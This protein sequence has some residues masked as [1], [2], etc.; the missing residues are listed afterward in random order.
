MAMFKDAA[1]AALDP[2]NIR[3]VFNGVIELDFVGGKPQYRIGGKVFPDLKSAVKFKNRAGISVVETFTPGKALVD[4]AT[5]SAGVPS[6]DQIHQMMIN[7]ARRANVKI[8]LHHLKNE[9][10][11]PSNLERILEGFTDEKT[12]KL[13][14]YLNVGK[15]ST[16]EQWEDMDNPGRFL[17][18][19]EIID[20]MSTVEKIFNDEVGSAAK[21]HKMDTRTAQYTKEFDRRLTVGVYDP[22]SFLKSSG[23]SG[24]DDITPKM[25][26]MSQDGMSLL[27]PEIIDEIRAAK[28]AQ[29][30]EYVAA[31]KNVPK[32][33]QKYMDITSEIKKIDAKVRELRGISVN[34]GL[35]N[36]RADIF[37]VAASS[38]YS[39]ALKG[40]IEHL[41]GQLKGN[42]MVVPNRKN[43]AGES[44][45]EAAQVARGFSRDVKLAVLTTAESI[46]QNKGERSRDASRVSTIMLDAREMIKSNWLDTQTYAAH[47]QLFDNARMHRFTVNTFQKQADELVTTGRLPEGMISAFREA[48][49]KN[50]GVVGKTS[51]STMQAKAIL[52]FMDN[53]GNLNQNPKMMEMA[54]NSLSAFFMD[55]KDS[56]RARF[57]V[58]NQVRHEIADFANMRSALVGTKSLPALTDLE[59]GWITLDKRLGFALNNADI[60]RSY[61]A[62][63]GF[64]LDDLIGTH[65]RYDAD[66]KQYVIAMTRQPSDVGEIS[67]LKFGEFDELA[68]QILVQND[69]SWDFLD[70]IRSIDRGLENRLNFYDLD[71]ASRV[72]GVDSGTAAQVAYAQ[73]YNERSEAKMAKIREKNAQQIRDLE[74]SIKPATHRLSEGSDEIENLEGLRGRMDE[75]LDTRDKLLT[76]PELDLLLDDRYMDPAEIQLSGNARAKEILNEVELLKA[77]TRAAFEREMAPKI[78]IL[79]AQHL[80]KLNQTVEH[81]SGDWTAS[82]DAVSRAKKYMPEIYQLVERVDGNEVHKSLDLE[83]EKEFKEFKLKT[84]GRTITD[85]EMRAAFETMVNGEYELQKY[86]NTK[87]IMNTMLAD[88]EDQMD[89]I[90]SVLGK[91]YFSVPELEDAIDAA[92]KNAGAGMHKDEAYSIALQRRIGEAAAELDAKGGP[93]LRI[94]RNIF[95]DRAGKDARSVIYGGYQ[96]KSKGKGS[97]DDHLIDG[98]YSSL[99]EAQKMTRQSIEDIVQSLTG[100]VK[101]DEFYS[102]HIFS[103]QAL[104]DAEFL[105]RAFHVSKET[106]K[107]AG[108]KLREIAD[109]FLR[110][111]DDILTGGMGQDEYSKKLARSKVGDDMLS[112][113]GLIGERSGQEG[114]YDALGALQQM[115]NDA[116]RS[117]AAR[118]ARSILN[119]R[120]ESGSMLDLLN[121]TDAHFGIR[122]GLVERDI[123][124]AGLPRAPKHIAAAEKAFYGEKRLATSTIATKAS[125]GIISIGEGISRL[126]EVPGVKTAAVVGLATVVGSFL[127]QHHKDHTEESMQGPPLLPGGSAYENL[128]VEAMQTGMGSRQDTRIGD[129]YSIHA[130]GN[131][132]HKEFSDSVSQVTGSPSSV[133]VYKSRNPKHQGSMD[134]YVGRRFN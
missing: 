81:V 2:D 121:S 82:I 98:G 128:P 78:P 13:A 88:N 113:V 107:G 24:M 97:F 39:G 122:P 46:A 95:H 102:K 124:I 99:V 127:Y 62:L 110:Y 30:R 117:E 84:G 33:S 64:D 93:S 65:A 96:A 89:E 71:A 44:M 74:I 120:G 53:G 126:K 86:S 36:I 58:P 73:A 116:P 79:K 63:G 114:V 57:M 91:G 49:E 133:S 5:T 21:R 14:G 83:L 94:D 47:P 9:D 3:Q 87:M 17:T 15:S 52:E 72:A 70:Q 43:A 7:Y 76:T 67:T 22:Y 59:E 61:E 8:H 29:K 18:N 115:H 123:D 28:E 101:Y 105:T 66:A 41:S 60:P 68:Q 50:T 12:G 118:R 129:T 104:D 80:E 31:R 90:I 35:Y 106:N 45:F 4:Y 111:G 19:Q 85:K 55:G 100:K 16:F 23:L 131:F 112:A 48:V 130:T 51:A 75:L 40:S 25:A 103:Q 26:Q 32:G 134:S 69:E 10:I 108:P 56:S 20:R 92:T 11:D 125:Q 42:V 54:L 27:N 109:S 119:S 132:D 6:G 38:H 77:Q 1:E 34:G 37:D